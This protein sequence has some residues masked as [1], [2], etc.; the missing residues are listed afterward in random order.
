MNG[1]QVDMDTN[2][3]VSTIVD[4]PAQPDEYK[5][6]IGTILVECGRLRESD[7]DSVERYAIKKG[8]RFGEAAVQLK[9][10][11]Q[12]DVDLALAQQFHYPILMRGGELGIAEDVIAAYNP[13][14][15]QVEPLR[16]LRSQ[17]T[18]RWRNLEHRKALAITSPNR[19]DGRSWLAANL[20]TV[21]AQAG[22]RTLLIDT[23]MRHPSQHR[24][25]NLNN[26]VGLSALLTGRAVGKD[27]V[28]RIHPGLRL[29]VIPAGILPPNPQELL[30]RPMF[31]AMLV[32]LAQRF[33]VIILDT[34]AATEAAD[35]QILSARAGAAVVLARR[36]RTRVSDLTATMASLSEIGVN[37]IGS[38][39]N[40]Y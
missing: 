25:F 4:A 14:S 40:D 1:R 12:Q 21:F 29:F 5:R 35:A 27:V 3:T 7:V 16:A 38:V 28:R 17:L 31:D 39:V 37:V 11:S 36:D 32:R 8:L 20:A 26:A 18:L 13:Q 34:P 33:S 6:A 24:L 15:D 9:L 10:V 30:I 19:G 22:D 23:D 2:L